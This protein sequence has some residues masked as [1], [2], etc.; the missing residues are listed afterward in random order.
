MIYLDYS[1]TTPCSAEAIKA[2]KDIMCGDCANPSSTHT[3]GQHSAL[4]I[5]KARKFFGDLF[6][7]QPQQVIFVSGG[8]E[9][10][11]LALQ[12]AIRA[13]PSKNH[14]ITTCIEHPAVSSTCKWLEKQGITITYLPVN[15][16]GIVDLK[17][18]HDS[19]TPQTNI[20]SIIH[21]NNEIG[22]VQPL[23]DIG[24][25]IRDKNKDVWFHTDAV[26]SFG[27]VPIPMEEA[28]IDLISISGH[29]IYGPV[30]TGALIMSPRVK[31]QP[32]LFG[33][34]Q[35]YGL[36]AG[37]E[38]Y[39][40]IHGLHTAASILMPTHNESMEKYKTLKEKFIKGIEQFPVEV[41]SPSSAVPYITT[42]ASHKL[43]GSIAVQKFNDLGVAVSAGSAC[44]ARNIKPSHVVLAMGYQ[45]EIA[46]GTVRFSFG[47][48][49]TS[50]QID[51]AIEAVGKVYGV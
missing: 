47:H 21:V 6:Q 31:L 12:G 38:N 26:Q 14:I 9:S 29:K 48:M 17:K 46:E 44:G 23:S 37:T 43:P 5:F 45:K 41:I 40:G 28:G 24:K 27:K 34:K 39:V 3:P 15:K 32:L 42:I 2:M 18:L 19:I 11:N 35:E 1:A 13:R 36:R 25:V 8:T 4:T 33:G 22:S 30:G 50:D 51:K 20:V 10:D 7:L 49:T 16:E